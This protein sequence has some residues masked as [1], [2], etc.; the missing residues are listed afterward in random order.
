M[1]ELSIVSSVLDQLGEVRAQQG[2]AA[3]TKVCL[4]IGELAGVDVDWLRVRGE[5]H[6]VERARA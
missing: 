6:R 5:G 4:R 1:H 2:G 3:I